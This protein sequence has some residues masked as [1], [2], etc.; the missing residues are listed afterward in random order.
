MNGI[1]YSQKQIA[2]TVIPNNLK[3]N[4]LSLLLYYNRNVMIAVI[5]EEWFRVMIK[6][7]FRPNRFSVMIS[8]MG[9]IFRGCRIL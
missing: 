8:Y 5:V 7:L 3:E 1:L 9:R 6:V 2:Y 4:L